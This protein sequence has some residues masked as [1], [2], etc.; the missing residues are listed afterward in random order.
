[1]KITVG[2]VRL[3]WGML[4]ILAAISYPATY[5]GPISV[6]GLLLAFLPGGGGLW[7][8]RG[9]ARVFEGL[10]YLMNQPSGRLSLGGAFVLATLVGL[11]FNPFVAFALTGLFLT[12]SW[13]LGV[14]C[15]RTRRRERL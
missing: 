12:L 8:A 2:K 7:T 5:V 15:A 10:R 4:V 6:A 14:A 13:G 9:G 11:T 3:A 1:M